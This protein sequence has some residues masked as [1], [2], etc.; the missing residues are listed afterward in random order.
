MTPAFLLGFDVA[1]PSAPEPPTPAAPRVSAPPRPLAAS[2]VPGRLE[3][4]PEW[5]RARRFLLMLSPRERA[6]VAARPRFR[7]I[8]WIRRAAD[9][10]PD[11]LP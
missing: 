7:N 10:D 2:P 8:G 5:F 11:E 1:P 6:A 4:S 9:A 3:M